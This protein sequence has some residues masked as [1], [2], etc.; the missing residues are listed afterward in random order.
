MIFLVV[1]DIDIHQLNLKSFKSLQ[2]LVENPFKKCVFFHFLSNKFIINFYFWKKTI[3]FIKK[4]IYRWA[5]YYFLVFFGLVMCH[6]PQTWSPMVIEKMYFVYFMH[7]D[8]IQISSS[9]HWIKLNYDSKWTL[10]SK[11]LSCTF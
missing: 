1:S 2:F 6:E 3:T 11:I 7:I 10:S 5:L 9:N 8:L 4:K